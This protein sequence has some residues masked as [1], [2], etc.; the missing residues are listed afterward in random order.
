MFVV[1]QMDED[2]RRNCCQLRMHLS[3]NRLKGAGARLCAGSGASFVQYTGC[4]SDILRNGDQKNT[5]DTH[6]R[7]RLEPIFITLVLIKYS[8]HLIMMTAK[9]ICSVI[10]FCNSVVS[11]YTIYISWVLCCNNAMGFSVWSVK[12]RL[13]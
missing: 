3:D 12:E 9:Y 2:S 4:T 5:S 6:L 7:I 8:K 1:R 10:L 11:L 13:L